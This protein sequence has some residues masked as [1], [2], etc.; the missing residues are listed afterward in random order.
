[1]GASAARAGRSSATFQSQMNCRS[2]NRYGLVSTLG[3]TDMSG[4]RSATVRGT[5][6]RTTLPAG[7]GGNDDVRSAGSSVS[8]Q[9]YADATDVTR[10]VGDSGSSRLAGSA[11]SMGRE[12]VA[13]PG[14]GHGQSLL[15]SS[16]LMAPTCQRV[17]VR[18]RAVPWLPPMGVATRRR[19]SPARNRPIPPITP[20]AFRAPFGPSPSQNGEFRPSPR[21]PNTRS[22]APKRLEA[23]QQSLV[24]ICARG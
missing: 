11:T 17:R 24:P 15:L 4:G 13:D 14:E 7:V 21:P 23:S 8:R 19:H 16:D 6:R 5:R 3:R 9:G 10:P 1:M 12:A 22:A 2:G 20:P 18:S